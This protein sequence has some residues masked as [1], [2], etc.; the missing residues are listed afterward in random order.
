[1]KYLIYIETPCCLF[2]ILL[3]NND[4]QPK[5][6]WPIYDFNFN[7]VAIFIW[8]EVTTNVLLWCKIIYFMTI[9]VIL[10]CSKLFHRVYFIHSKKITMDMNQ[11]IQTDDCIRKCCNSYGCHT[12]LNLQYILSCLT[13]RSVT[14][15]Y[16][17]TV[18]LGWFR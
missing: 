16:T 12:L 9:Y 6:M 10:S 14:K 11:Y 5:D 7:L 17:V 1:M 2:S 18:D 8:I 15:C 13:F 4:V 3:Y